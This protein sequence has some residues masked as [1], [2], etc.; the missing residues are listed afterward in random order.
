MRVRPSP[1]LGDGGTCD[2][3]SHQWSTTRNPTACNTA[4]TTEEEERRWGW[5]EGMVDRKWARPFS[6]SIFVHIHN[7]I[8]NHSRVAA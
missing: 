5:G 2:F 1:A 6:S 8:G 7:A 4:K 3:P